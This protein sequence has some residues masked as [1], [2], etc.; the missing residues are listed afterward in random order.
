M[1]IKPT[2]AAAR[3]AKATGG[4]RTFHAVDG[5]AN[6]YLCCAATEHKKTWS[7]KVNIGGTTRRAVLGQWPAMSAREARI[8]APLAISKLRRGEAVAAETP[9]P[10]G[11]SLGE[12][13][14]AYE[15]T[16]LSDR[17]AGHN[18][19][20]AMRNVFRKLLTE[21]L[22]VITTGQ[23]QQA[24]NTKK[25]EGAPAMAN[26]TA[27]YVKAFFKWASVTYDLEVNP[28]LRLTAVAV[29]VFRDRVLDDDELRAIW[30]AADTMP[31]PYGP[32]MQ[33][34]SLSAVRRGEAAGL[35]IDELDLADG[36]WTIPAER[37]KVGKA[38]KI[39]LSGAAVDILREAIAASPDD[40]LVFCYSPGQVPQNFAREKKRLDALCGVTDWTV[41]DL[42]TA[43]ATGLAEL[44]I[45][46]ATCD[47]VLNHMCSA[48]RSKIHATY[49]RTDR[50]EPRRVALET[51]AQHLLAL[52]GEGPAASNVR[53]LRA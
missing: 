1:S 52:A 11:P 20:L 3:A 26:R 8:E 41:H 30:Q 35:T 51:W 39:P 6:L 32:I 49:Q 17:K 14:K 4:K 5:V 45:D 12:A 48:S 29:E 21:P 9:T 31:Y 42:R 37:S 44:G 16:V 19:A 40:R 25:V 36:L 18:T 13:L 2:D 28:A 15:A 33:F 43:I 22:K 47:A 50:I 53:R 23:L 34:L 10:G 27:S 7:V 38:R 46:E 24:V